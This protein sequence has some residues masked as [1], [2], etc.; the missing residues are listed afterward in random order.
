[1]TV[2]KTAPN[3]RKVAL[4][5]VCFTCRHFD[6]NHGDVACR[7]YDKICA[8]NGSFVCVNVNTVCDDWQSKSVPAE[9]PKPKTVVTRRAASHGWEFE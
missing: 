6:W 2:K 1:M 4:P 8:S 5:D 3:L 9:Q 7:K